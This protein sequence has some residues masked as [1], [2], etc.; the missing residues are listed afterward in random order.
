[1]PAKSLSIAAALLFSA[2]LGAAS[3]QAA[4]LAE[5]QAACEGDAFEYCSAYI[6]NRDEIRGCLFEYRNEISPACRAL[7]APR[8]R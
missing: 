4:T 8:D 1:M 6:P 2:M 5:E 7:V 3:A